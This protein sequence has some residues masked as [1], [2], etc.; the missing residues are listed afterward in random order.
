MAASKGIGEAK[1]R[2]KRPDG[3]TYPVPAGPEPS[4]DDLAW[5]AAK[6]WDAEHVRSLLK[7]DRVDLDV[8]SVELP[9]DAAD[10]AKG[11]GLNAH[12]IDT[13]Y[14]SAIME[15]YR[16]QV[17]LGLNTHPNP[18]GAA[19]KGMLDSLKK[20]EHARKYKEFEDRGKDGV[21]STY[22]DLE[23]IRIQE[24]LL[25]VACSRKADRVAAPSRY[26]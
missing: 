10:G 9:G 26:F 4:A 7:E 11:G 13:A 2:Q 18:R 17:S 5:G 16:V 20:A 19:L 8:D 24:E 12:T 14:V 15:L 22:S 25:S 1:K 6:G 3:T 23:L 21:N